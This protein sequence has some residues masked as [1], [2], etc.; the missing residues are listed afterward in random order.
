MAGQKIISQTDF[1][2][3]LGIQYPI[4]GGAMYPCSNPELV[5]AVSEAGGIGIVQPLSLVYAHGYEIEKGFDYI[6]SLTKKPIGMN[7]I[8][9]KGSKL[10]EDRMKTWIDVALAH[11]V[12]FFI[13]ALGNPAWVVKKVHEASGIVYHN[14]TESRWAK[15]AVTEG[16]DGLIAVNERAGGHCGTRSIVALYDELK[17]FGLPLVAA[18]GISTKAQIEDALHIGYEAVQMGTRFV[19]SKECK[20]PEE[21]KQAIVNANASDIVRT[22]RVTGV[23]LSV[24]RNPYVMQVGLKVDPVSRFLFKFRRTRHLL[25][26]LYNIRAA[27]AFKK[28]VQGTGST[29][30]YWQAGGSVEGIKSI[31]TVEEIM[32]ELIN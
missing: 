14:T 18:G 24:I 30:D 10:Y 4:I 16:V 19:A 2:R 12:R 6:R 9:E 31:G 11:G 13:T 22:E 29:K 32:R 17:S 28:T 27:R 3:R 8:V 23:P 1:C 15:R 7:V 25:R 26:L 21:Y 5:A 20:A